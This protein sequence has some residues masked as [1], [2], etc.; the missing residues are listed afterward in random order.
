MRSLHLNYYFFLL[1]YVSQGSHTTGELI[2]VMWTGMSA[3]R[4]R[5]MRDSV[6]AETGAPSSCTVLDPATQLLSELVHYNAALGGVIRDKPVALSR[7]V[8]VRI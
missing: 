6:E 7:R 5:D 2:G 8:S 3:R 4:S 1:Q